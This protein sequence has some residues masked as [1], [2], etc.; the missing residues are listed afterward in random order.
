MAD[1]KKETF[2]ES[3]DKRIFVF[4]RASKFLLLHS[5]PVT[6]MWAAA[7][8]GEILKMYGLVLR[9]CQDYKK[10]YKIYTEALQNIPDVIQEMPPNLS[11]VRRVLDDDFKAIYDSLSREEKRTLWR[12]IISEIK[13]DRDNNITDIIFS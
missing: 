7:I 8:P 1:I 3:V 5:V 11:A 10:D 13:V 6:F 2:L 12:S 9:P 4:E